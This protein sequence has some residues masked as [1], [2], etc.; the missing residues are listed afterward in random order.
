MFPQGAWKFR[1]LVVF[2][3]AVTL[4]VALSAVLLCGC[5]GGGGGPSPTPKIS[6]TVT[7]PQGTPVAQAPSFLQ[8]LA[9]LLISVA[10]AQALTG[11]AVANATVKAFIW[12]NVPQTVTTPI[13]T[14][15]TDNNGRYT[16]QLPANAVG[17]DVVVIAEKSVEGGTLRL[18]TIVADVPK[19]GKVGV[20]LDAAT[21]LATEQIVFVAKSQN[22][23]DF[24]PNAISVIISNIRD[25]VSQL[26]QLNLIAGA[27]DSPIPL[28]FGEGLKE[29]PPASQVAEK[30]EDQ[31]NN[32]P[33]PTGDAAIAKSIVQM[34]RDFSSTL[35]GIGENE[36]VTIQNAVEEQQRVISNEIKVAEDF[37]KRMDFP[38]RALSA[39]EGEPPGAYEE[40]SFGELERV[41][42]TDDKTWRVTSKVGET[43]GMVLTITS[44][45]PM[46]AFEFSPAAG[47]YTL[48][49]RKQGDPT[50][51][52]DGELKFTT[53]SQGIPTAIALNITIRDK[54][55]SKPISFNGNV[56]GVIASGS[57]PE[58]PEYSKISF[59][60]ALSSQFGT[61]QV[62]KLEVV[63]TVVNGD[64]MV[65]KIA[66][67]N[68]KVATQTSKPASLTL[69]GTI[70]MEPTPPQWQDEWGDMMPKL[71]SI[72]ATLQA[73][74]ITLSLSNAQV[75]DFVIDEENAVPRRLSGK[76]NYTS[77]TL[78]FQGNL[79]AFYE[80]LGAAT[81]SEQVKLTFSLSG[82]WKPT[83]GSPLSV[84]I[85]TTSTPQTITIELT[86]NQGTQ[87]LAGD[88][89][90]NWKFVGNEAKI[91]NGALNLTHSPSNFK[92][93]VS[94]QEGQPAT[95]TIKT[96]QGQTVAQIGE[97][98]SLGVDLGKTMI[99][100]YNDGTFETL[101]SILPRSRMSRR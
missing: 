9:S 98:Q 31:Q 63:T 42:N 14:T 13:A 48:T 17:K 21:T 11:Q 18:S 73:S 71:G 83:V 96:A 68:L 84:S 86:L 36:V 64:R 94:F 66:L 101:Q 80:G 27:E 10:E 50:V 15:Q 67:T 78:T 20:N 22:I 4:F 3:V 91:A 100:K 33:A 95:G 34:L 47:V 72:S 99:V 79:N 43:Q 32:L 59:S 7:A 76:L 49:V 16:L 2:T 38:I 75:S 25:I 28:N 61:A 58:E 46:E 40:V 37:G 81:A 97:A 88:F 65:Q 57:T 87:K 77:P 35:I 45:R 90:G 5:G 89:V 92:V 62:E 60:G 1:T 74:G 39:L 12:P 85:S 30:V 24:S 93:Q 41:G 70:E 55:L 52:Y 6:G 29:V 8:R 54:E 44:Q 56:S 51:Q 69:N 53:N 23:S 19:E 82:N 26:A